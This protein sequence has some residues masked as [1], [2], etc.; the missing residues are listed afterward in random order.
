[1]IR[2][3][4]VLLGMLGVPVWTQ[5]NVAAAGSQPTQFAIVYGEESKII[6]RMIE[7]EDGE[8]DDLLRRIMTVP[9]Q[10][11]KILKLD[12][13]PVFRRVRDVQSAIGEPIGSGRC[14][15]VKDGVVVNV[16]HADPVL[17]EDLEYH[18]VWSDTLGIGDRVEVA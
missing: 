16:I 6:H 9:G 10:A 3:R 11:I 12:D 15:L 17:Y 7:L 13:Y 14:A 18:L 4:T 1:M 2:R 5:V 8:S